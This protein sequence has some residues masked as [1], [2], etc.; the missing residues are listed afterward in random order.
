MILFRYIVHL[1]LDCIW[2]MDIESSLR[3]ILKE[4]E[5][6]DR[7]RSLCL[8]VPIADDQMIKTLKK[9]D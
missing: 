6:D 5:H 2:N 1:K 4:I 7:L 8:R 9:N 3:K